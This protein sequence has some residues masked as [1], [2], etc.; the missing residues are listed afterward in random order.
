MKTLIKLSTAMLI[1]LMMSCN[2]GTAQQAKP[3][4]PRPAGTAKS[5]TKI[6][7][8]L[9]LDASN[10]MDGL[11]D[12]AKSRLWNIVNTLSTLKFEEKTPIIE[13]ALYMYGN[14]G[15]SVRDNYIKQLTPF[16]SDL[17]LISEKLFAI[18]TNGGSE[19][20]GAVIEQAV[21]KLDWGR[22]KSD[23]RLIYIAG[24]EP[25][26]QGSI[27]YH[28]AISAANAKD[29]YVN[30]IFCGSFSEGV[31]THWKDG[32]DKGKGK[33]FN[34]NSNEKVIYVVTPYDDLI[35][36]CNERLN[37]TY[38]Y[39]GYEG[40]AKYQNQAVQD[41][42]SKTISTA[43]YAERSVSKSKSNYNNASWDLVDKMVSDSTVIAKVNKKE[44]PKQYQNLTDGE[45]KAE[46]AKKTKE[47]QAIQKEIGSLAAKRQ[48]YIN[49]YKTQTAQSDDIGNAINSTIIEVAKVKGYKVN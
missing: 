5:S 17:D 43:N 24:N 29:I 20:C 4:D 44:L 3:I 15:I 25:F 49:N 26:T 14:D 40:E 32:A 35:L 34:I 47:R 2:L 39:Y 9:L 12:Q 28:E 16:T 48:E 1:T 21:Q 19:Y 41:N 46:I 6:Q 13:I 37:A 10:S 33:Y 18:S 11:I 31:N 23:M 27:N 42:N 7:V 38:I 36:R 22:E 30:T 8:A 45:L